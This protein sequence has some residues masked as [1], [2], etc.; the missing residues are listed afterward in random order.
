[1]MLAFSPATMQVYTPA[2]ALQL[3]DFPAAVALVPE[4]ALIET[5]SADA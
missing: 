5:M 4:V 3:T 2:L 1:M